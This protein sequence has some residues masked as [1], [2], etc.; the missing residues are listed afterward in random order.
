MTVGRN[1]PCP[2]GSG[3]KY[4]NCCLGRALPAERRKLIALVAVL[5]A[6]SAGGGIAVGFY[7]GT[8]NGILGGLVGLVAIG[9]FL[10]LRSPPKSR[11]R[12]GSD[13]ID[14]GR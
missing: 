5:V 9:I 2:C 6:A 14:F 11:G 7:F 1:A 12:S 3:K 10:A 13:R 4:K 8:S